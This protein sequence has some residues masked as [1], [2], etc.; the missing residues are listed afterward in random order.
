MRLGARGGV[1][2][3]LLRG[4]IEAEEEEMRGGGIGH[5][6]QCGHGEAARG[7]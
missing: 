2:K 5:I 6:R 7:A 3:K 4:E 1:L